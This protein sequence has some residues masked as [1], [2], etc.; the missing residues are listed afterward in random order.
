MILSD[1]FNEEPNFFKER[2][3][4]SEKKFWKYMA[5]Q[6]FSGESSQPFITPLSHPTQFE[7]GTKWVNP[8]SGF[9][10]DVE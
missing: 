8:S 6:E 1:L 4:T 5:E 10:W 3:G 7:K 9:T 2:L